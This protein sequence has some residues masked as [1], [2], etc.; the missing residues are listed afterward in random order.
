[1]QSTADPRELTEIR[2][3]GVT[4]SLITR[5]EKRLCELEAISDQPTTTDHAQEL[6]VKLETLDVDFKAYHLQL[7]DLLDEGE[8]EVLEREQE[9]LDEHDDLVAD[10]NIRLKHLGL[11]AT[12]SS[13]DHQKLS[14]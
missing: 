6:T 4:H 8:D 12:P 13:V 5:L 3:R 9:I 11:I 7:V 10:M 2:R 14:S 1:M